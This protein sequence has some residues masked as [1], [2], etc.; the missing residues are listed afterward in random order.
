MMAINI[1]KNMPKLF[2]K[3]FKNARKLLLKTLTDFSD[4]INNYSTFDLLKTLI[5]YKV[6]PEFIDMPDVLKGDTVLNSDNSINQKLSYLFDDYN[7]DDSYEE[8]CNSNKDIPD[9]Q[10]LTKYSTFQLYQIYFEKYFSILADET[11]KK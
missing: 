6:I 4:K 10:K 5:K 8:V 2:R 3:I 7:Q 9:Y 11:K 1:T